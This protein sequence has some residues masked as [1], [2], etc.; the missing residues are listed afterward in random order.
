MLMACLTKNVAFIANTARHVVLADWI[1]TAPAILGQFVTGTLLMEKLQYSFESPWFMSVFSLFAFIG[2]C[3]VPVVFIQ[4]RMKKLAIEAEVSGV[5]SD[6]FYRAMKLW[7]VL[8]IPAFISILLILGLMVFK[9]LDT[10]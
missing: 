5:L 9:P 3:W 6:K 10:M 1:F 4:Y 7:I 8:G 2:C